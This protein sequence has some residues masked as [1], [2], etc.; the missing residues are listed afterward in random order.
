MIA[1]S[2]AVSS[3]AHLPTFS[4]LLLDN[5]LITAMLFAT[6]FL[7][8]LNVAFAFAAR[9]RRALEIISFVVASIVELAIFV[10][11]LALRIHPLTQIPFTLP[12]GLPIDRAEIGATLALAIGLFPAAYWHRTSMSQLR[13]RM[14]DDARV[15][16]NRDG[17]RIRGNSPG[18]WLN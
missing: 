10:L 13:Q 5:T 14:A 16:K 12:T 17:V 3:T 6:A 4:H 15:I 9:K 8:V 7:I 2:L 18:E 11:V 1:L